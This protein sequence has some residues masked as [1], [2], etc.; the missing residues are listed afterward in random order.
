MLRYVEATELKV[1][2]TC[3]SNSVLERLSTEVYG[4]VTE[5]VKKLSASVIPEGVHCLQTGLGQTRF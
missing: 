1:L 4:F 2:K 5:L 3:S